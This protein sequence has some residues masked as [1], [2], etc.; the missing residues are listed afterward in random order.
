[1]SARSGEVVHRIK[2]DERARFLITTHMIGGIKVV[3]LDTDTLLWHL[4]EVSSL[5][6]VSEHSSEAG[7]NR[8]MSEAGPIANT[9]TGSSSSTA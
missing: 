1:M 3:D 7:C 2:V 4:P 9:K 8:L 6:R 5:S